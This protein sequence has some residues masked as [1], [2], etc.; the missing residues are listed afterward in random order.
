MSCQKRHF[1]ITSEAG[2]WSCKSRFLISFLNSIRSGLKPTLMGTK[3]FT[4]MAQIRFFFLT[5]NMVGVNLMATVLFW[6]GFD[7]Y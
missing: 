2:F 3:N 7:S 4:K 6:H 5:K 1:L